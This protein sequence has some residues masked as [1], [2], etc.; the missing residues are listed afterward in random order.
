VI[1]LRLASLLD[2]RQLNAAWSQSIKS[3]ADEKALRDELCQSAEA[4][5]QE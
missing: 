3:R 2:N 1:P 4:D 5:S